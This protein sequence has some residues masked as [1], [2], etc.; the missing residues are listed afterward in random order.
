MYIAA[1]VEIYENNIKLCGKFANGKNRKE[2]K[3]SL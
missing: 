3:I 1:L 2:K